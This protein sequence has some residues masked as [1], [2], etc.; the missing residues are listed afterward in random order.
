MTFSNYGFCYCCNQITKFEAK[1]EWWRD[2]Y[3]CVTCSSIPRERAVMY[4]LEKYFPNWTNLLIHESSPGNR[5]AS[6]RI[7]S[8]AKFYI[9]SH[10]YSNQSAGSN[11]NGFRNE[12]LETLT[13]IDNSIDLHIS[14][15]VFEHVLDPARAFR[16]I[17]RTLKPGGAHI[18]TTPLVNKNNPSQVCARRSKNGRIEQIIFPREYHGNPISNEGSLVTMHWGY[19]ITSYIHNASGLFTEI[20]LIDAID[21]GIRAELNEVL[22]SRKPLI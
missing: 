17:A 14:Q 9:Q 7:R 1:G 6:V 13:F 5:G 20:V 15:D 11:V 2:D 3:I 21:L 4:C 8:E 22:I 12:N 16:E 18:F 10:Y 19:D